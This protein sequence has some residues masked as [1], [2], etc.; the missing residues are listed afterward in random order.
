MQSIEENALLSAQLKTVSQTLQ[1]N[2]LRYTD[3]QNR[4]L[5]L[6]REYQVQVASGQGTAQVRSTKIF[7]V[8]LHCG[9]VYREH[10]FRHCLRHREKLKSVSEDLQISLTRFTKESSADND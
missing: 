5:L 6:E 1:D 3:L 8:N 4:Y 10:I 7:V 2:Q 9:G